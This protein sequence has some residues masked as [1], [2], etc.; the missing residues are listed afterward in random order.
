MASEE[1]AAVQVFRSKAVRPKTNR[2]QP[3]GRK[4]GRQYVGVEVEEGWSNRNEKQL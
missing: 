4:N 3:L 2:Q 1:C